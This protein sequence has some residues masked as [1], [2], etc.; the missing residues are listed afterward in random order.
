MPSVLNI[1]KNHLLV[2]LPINWGD[3][4][5]RMVC[6]YSEEWQVS[7][8]GWGT[9]EVTLTRGGQKGR[10]RAGFM[11][12]F[13]PSNRTAVLFHVWQIGTHWKISFG[14]R[15]LCKKKKKLENHRS[16]QS[17]LIPFPWTFYKLQIVSSDMRAVTG[18]PERRLG[19]RGSQTGG[20]QGGPGH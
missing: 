10:W 7:W 20:P 1:C 19:D 9:W 14:K 4:P 18:P 2:S 13:S 6:K 12:S 11:T 17:L 16:R 5:A 8:E 3:C 15:I